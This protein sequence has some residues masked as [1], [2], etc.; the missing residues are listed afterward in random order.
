MAR[1]A[2]IPKAIKKQHND[3]VDEEVAWLLA[4]Q[5]LS[6]PKPRIGISAH[7]ADNRS[8]VD[9]AYSDALSCG[10]IPVILPITADVPRLLDAL[11]EVDAL[12]LTGGVDISPYYLGEEPHPSLGVVQPDRDAYEFRL[13]RLARRLSLPILGICRGHQMLGVAYGSTLLQDIPSQY[14]IQ[15][16]LDHA[17]KLDK[18]EPHH[19]LKLSGDSRLS[20]LLASARDYGDTLDEVWVNSLHHQGLREVCPPFEEVAIAPDGINE[21]ID[22][23]PEL[24]ILAVQWHPEHLVGG[25]ENRHHKLFEHIIKRAELYQR[26]RLFHRQHITLDSHTDTPMFFAE[27]FDIASSDQT[28]VDLCKMEL[29]AIDASVMV[30]YLPQGEC[31]APAYE[32]AFAKTDAILT[33]LHRQVSNHRERAVIASSAEAIRSAKALG[34]RVIIPAIENG[35]AIGEELAKLQYYRDRYGI[36]YMTL[37]HNG[38]NAICDSAARSLG[39]HGGLSPFG[40]EV[41]REMNRLGLVID[42]SHTGENTVRDVLAL[43]EAPVVASHSS[44]RALCNHVRNLTDDQIIAIAERGGVVQV[45]L[46][47]G[48][49][50][51][52]DKEASLLDAVEH[53]EHIIRLVGVRHV[54]IGSDFDGDGELIGCRSSEDLIRITIELL[55]RGYTEEDLE[56]IWGGNFLRVLSACQALAQAKGYL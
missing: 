24:D 56:A 46:Y 23:Y 18:R 30:A 26:A 42:L 43:S 21:A 47:A 13:I 45:C 41:V 19:R 2:N 14:A 20:R 28:R 8:C 27:G 35:Y 16:A 29:G 44:A 37:C 34:L 48:F 6:K 10:A 7:L 31:S 33:E 1:W 17:P 53:I 5:A 3:R 52:Q 11:R 36:V 22:A 49:I 9:R 55:D 50:N 39:T 38:D 25:V 4:E 51:E 32:E 15:E 12:V 54:G 40:R